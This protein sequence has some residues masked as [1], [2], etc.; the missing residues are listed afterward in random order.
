VNGPSDPHVSITAACDALI[1]AAVTEPWA[2][3]RRKVA[4]WFGRGQPDRKTLERLDRTRADIAAAPAREAERVRNELAREW[5]GRF[6]DLI[7]DHPDAAAELDGLVKDMRAV[8]ASDHSVAAGGD[9]TSTADRGSVAAAVIHGDVHT[10]TTIEAYV[11]APRD[12]PSRLPVSLPPRLLALAGRE[13][14]LAELDELLAG[15]GLPWPRTVVLCG[16]GGVGKTSLAAEYAHRNLAN[17]SVAW[18]LAAENPDVL[19]VEVAELAAQLG[20]RDLADPRDPVA[21]AHAV[22]AAWP[23]QWLLIY[24]NA[25]DEDSVRRLLPPAGQGRVLVTSQSQHWPARQVLEVPVLDPEVA[26][27]FLVSRAGDPNP[28]AAAALGGELGGLPLALEQAAAY[29]QATGGSL[30]GYLELFRTRRADLVARGEAAAH[31]AGVAATLALAL[32]RLQA[33]APAAVGLLR[34]LACLAPEPVPVNALLASADLAGSLDRTVAGELGPLLA[35]GLATGDAVA[36]LR[37]Y[38][39]VSPA[40]ERTV[41]VHRLVQA[42]TLDQMPCDQVAAWRQAAGV[43]VEAA[44]PADTDLPGNWP[45]CA[46]LLPHAAAVV[47]LTRRGMSRIARYLGCAGSYHAARDLYGQI[48][49]AHEAS[50]GYGAEDPETLTARTS[51]AF[52]TGQAGDPAAARDQYARLVPLIQKVHGIEHP[53]TLTARANLAHWTGRAG[54]PAAARQQYAAVLPDHEKMLGAEQPETLRAPG[55]LVQFTGEAGDA[56]AARDHFV[57]LLPVFDKVLGGEHPE[58]LRARASLAA[59]TGEAGDPV[60]ARDQFVALLPMRERVLGAEHPETVT[61]RASLAYWTGRAGDAAAARALLIALLPIRE[62]VSG[63]EHP[64]TLTARGNLAYWTGRAGDAAAARDQYAALL[65]IE[66]RVRGSEHPATVVTRA[67]LA[68]WT[69]RAGDAAAARDQY[70]ALLP[71]CEKV[72]GAEHPS[73][74]TSRANFAYWT[75]RAGHAAAARD[76]YAAL[77]P[78]REKVL[79][80]EHPDTLAARSNLAYWTRR[81][82]DG[83]T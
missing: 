25:A 4:S 41:L 22:L 58:T 5:A 24:D 23:A 14:L 8:V 36:A 28:D 12:R 38:S 7:A 62:K 17:V 44:V 78:V 6:K 21:S 55:N 53:S 76:Q 27:G 51:L 34:L 61:A 74:L 75:G 80:V 1:T 52:W 83:A 63:A 11:E 31:T 59:F 47:D 39:L 33:D 71:V 64:D 16:L 82:S 66:E 49:E 46:L 40:G 26:A 37:R 72:L 54:N 13:K 50:P 15:G 19:A 32:S 67:G 48:A 73:T 68:Y 20:G 56:V 81:A 2:N 29:I 77:L 60:A 10:G 35:D 30:A 69:G 57:D 65:S 9:V 18:Q 45:A 43:L 70:A 3:V 42:V 79:G